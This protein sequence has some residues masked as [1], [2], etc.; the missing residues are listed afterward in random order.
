M[1]TPVRPIPASVLR[2]IAECPAVCQYVQMI[3]NAIGEDVNL[4]HLAAYALALQEAVRDLL[5]PTPNS[6]R[7]SSGTFFCFAP[8]K[9]QIS[10]AC[11]RRQGRLRIARSW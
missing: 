3:P 8:T 9:D 1:T 7:R 2:Y 10:S 5:S 11:T 4:S 6:P